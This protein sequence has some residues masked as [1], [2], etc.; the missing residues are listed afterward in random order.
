MMAGYRDRRLFRRADHVALRGNI[1]LVGYMLRV[2]MLAAPVFTPESLAALFRGLSDPA[3][4]LC[5]FS[6][7]ERSRTVGEIVA[8]TGLS[9]PNVSKH[10][11]CL[12]GCGLVEAERSGRF[13]VYRV[14]GPQVE[15]VLDAAD[16]LLRDVAVP[17][18]PCPVCGSLVVGRG[19]STQAEEDLGQHQ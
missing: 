10:L 14:A 16:L 8:E 19:G 11:A 2:D 15:R 18:G 1:F 6:V 3:R 12:R 17:R 5:L 13:V 9:Q 7:R 4:L